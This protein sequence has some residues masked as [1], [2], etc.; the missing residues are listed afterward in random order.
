MYT[1]ENAGQVIAFG[2]SAHNLVMMESELAIL[3]PGHRFSPCMNAVELNRLLGGNTLSRERAGELSLLVNLSREF[4][5]LDSA[6]RMADGRGIPV[7]GAVATDFINA[8]SLRLCL[9]RELPA[10]IGELN[11]R[12]ELGEARDAIRAGRRFVP[13]TLLR[14]EGY[15]FVDPAVCLSLL[16]DNE[17]LCVDA[18]L[19]GLSVKEIAGR[20]KASDSTVRTYVNRA[21]AKLGVSTA[22][23]LAWLLAGHPSGCYHRERGTRQRMLFPARKSRTD[24]KKP[25]QAYT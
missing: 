16:S 14:D 7:I 12:E 25:E 17:A 6:L 10:I 4:H 11:S 9:D 23:E 20:M 19:G 21:F 2:F 5:E 13:R 8:Y 1:K 24:I 22:E 15:R 3:W 18:R